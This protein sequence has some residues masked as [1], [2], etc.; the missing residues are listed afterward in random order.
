MK[1]WFLDSDVD[2]FVML[3]LGYYL[4]CSYVHGE[5]NKPLYIFECDQQLNCLIYINNILI[6]FIKKYMFK[7]WD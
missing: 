2:N 7:I 3:Y 6:K 4:R 1:Y 5:K